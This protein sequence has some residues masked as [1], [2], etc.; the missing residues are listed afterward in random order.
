MPLSTQ[1]RL[2]RVIQE[3]TFERVGGTETLTADVRIIAATNKNLEEEVKLRR[4]REDLYY[5]LNVIPLR[6]P[7]LRE[8]NG[9]I[10]L[11]VEYLLEKCTKKLS[12]TVR[13]S[14]EA[15]GA[16]LRYDYPGN[17]RE[18]E[19]IVERCATLAG[20]DVISREELPAFLDQK[21]GDIARP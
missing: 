4:F 18:L 19:N 1:T 6:L 3:K 11:L 21:A 17:V 15:M 9:D 2:L 20:S 8:R 16:L 10:S 14:D 7:P 12:R 13:F 5:R